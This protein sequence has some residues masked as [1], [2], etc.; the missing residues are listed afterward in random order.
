QGRAEEWQ[1]DP[2]LGGTGDAQPIAQLPPVEQ[3]MCHHLWAD[4][5]A[6][7][8]QTEMAARKCLVPAMSPLRNCPPLLPRSRP[9]RGK[10]NAKPSWQKKVSE[11]SGA[12]HGGFSRQIV[13]ECI[14]IH[15]ASTLCR[16]AFAEPGVHNGT[17]IAAQQ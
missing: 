4:V 6:L 3:E 10:A 15:V 2:A 11:Q 17:Q 8:K 13:F 12:G 5:A 1:S 16:Q 7:L 9:G 14:P